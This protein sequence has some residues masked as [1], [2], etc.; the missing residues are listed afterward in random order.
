MG[1][2]LRKAAVKTSVF[3]GA[4]LDGYLARANHELDWLPHGG[5]EDLGFDAFMASVDALVM[6]RKTYDKVLTFGTW[7]YGE[8]PVFVLSSRPLASAPSGATVERLSNTPE[9]IVSQ[10]A[11][12]GFRHLYVDGGITIQRFLQ[13]GL[14]RH[15]TITRVP[16]LIGDG[17]PLFGATPRDIPLRHIATR[18]FSNGLVQT[19]YEV[20]G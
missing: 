8:K 5:G 13:A 19:E 1:Q 9:E 14:I 17:I 2:P 3:V 11:A 10:L 12:R 4:S 15:L 7:P 6:G 16:V 18:T 20:L